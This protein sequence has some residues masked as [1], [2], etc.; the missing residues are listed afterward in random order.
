M[1]VIHVILLI[2][3]SFKAPDD[4]EEFFIGNELNWAAY[5]LYLKDKQKFKY[6]IKE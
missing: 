6:K 2:L 1:Q 3:H 5:N 4:S